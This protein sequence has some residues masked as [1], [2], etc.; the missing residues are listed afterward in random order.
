MTK[1]KKFKKRS[2]AKKRKDKLKKK[3]RGEACYLETS[4]QIKQIYGHPDEKK[5]IGDLISTKRSFI[6]SFI[7]REYQRRIIIPLI[8]FFFALSGEDNVSNAVDYMSNRVRSL[9][10]AKILMKIFFDIGSKY[11]DNKTGALSY[12]RFLISETSRLFISKA[13][14]FVPNLIDMDVL[15]VPSIDA[16]DEELEKFKKIIVC[17]GK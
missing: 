14:N 9:R 2:D 11:S 6:S 12:I 1:N 4:I 7:Y 13:N 16:E 10:D 17:T 3:N 15:K 8:D 5:I